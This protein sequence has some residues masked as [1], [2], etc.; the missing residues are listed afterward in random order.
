MER[1]LR[2]VPVTNLINTNTGF[3]KQGDRTVYYKRGGVKPK[4]LLF[5]I[6]SLSSLMVQ[7]PSETW[8]VLPLCGQF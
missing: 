8:S 1:I 5:K 6:Y 2:Q 7:F 3:R 4:A